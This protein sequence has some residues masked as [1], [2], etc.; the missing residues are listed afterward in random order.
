MVRPMP[1]SAIALLLAATACG[2]P[3]NVVLG[4]APAT[5]TSQT[6]IFDNINSV[7]SG[8]VTLTDASGNVVRQEGAI[9]ISDRPSL[10]DL[11]KA[12]PG[13]FSGT[14][15][16]SF[17]AL[18][19]IVPSDYL[20]TFLFGRNGPADLR[21]GSE[22]IGSIRG[23]P[24]TPHKVIYP[25]PGAPPTGYIALTNWSDHQ[26]DNSTGSFDLFY[27]NPQGLG[28]YEF[29]GRFKSNVCPAL[30]PDAVKLPGQW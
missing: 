21:S 20:G 4:A 11:L 3:D 10:C 8:H 5:A 7:I 27:S 26:G 19:L 13:Y 14:A 1:K 22:L 24:I 30:N 28:A 17:L 16:E 9:V 6:I 18:I 12:S 25:P 23:Q 29:S 2:N 15:S